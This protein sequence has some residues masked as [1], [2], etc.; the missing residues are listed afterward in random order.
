MKQ[1]LQY[2]R[3]KH[4]R[5]A[6]IPSP[7]LKGPG[8]VVGNRCSLISVG[9]E[10]QMI[11]VSQLSLLG[12]ARQ[13]PDIVKQVFSKLKTEG[14][15][16]TYNKVMGRLNSPVPL[17]YSSAGIVRQ[18]HA[19]IENWTVGERVACAGY[20]YA[21]HA[22]TVYVPV[23]L[24]VKIPDNVAN[25]EACFVTLG[26]I[27]MQ[28]IR[29][30]DVRLGERVAVIGLGLL[31]QI[32]CMLLAAAGCRVLGIDID[33]SKVEL[34]L[35]AGAEGVFTANGHEAEWALDA[36]SGRGVDATIITAASDT[37]TPLETAGRICREKGIVTVVGAVKLEVPR[38]TYYEKELDLRLSRSYGPG[39]YDYNYEEAG[40][41]YPYGYVR[42]TENRNMESFL[43][44]IS[45]GKINVK[46]LITHRFDLDQANRAYD[47][48]S[49]D[50]TEKY[51]GVILRY[52]ESAKSRFLTP[53]SRIEKPIRL[54]GNARIGVGFIGAGSF[55]SGVLL[56]SIR[57]IESFEPVAILSGSG[58]SAAAAADRFGFSK[59]ASSLSEILDDSSIKTVFIANRHDQHA[60]FVIESLARGKPTYVEKPLC[61]SRG[62][63]EQISRAY[64]S[65]SVPLMVGFNRRFSHLVE[66]IRE[67]IKEIRYPLSMHYRINAGYIP[68][69]NWIQDPGSG[70]G[71]IIG[72]ICH[73]V[74]LLSF[75][76]SSRPA[77]IS[78]EALSMPD[79]RYR[80]DDNLQIMIRFDSGSVGSINYMASGSKNMGKEYLEILGG[81]TAI[82]LDDFRVLT[83]ANEK[84]KAITR[85]R[86]QDK[87]HRKMLELWSY[88]LLAGL[89][90]PIP[91]EQ[92]V[93][94]TAAT[95]DIIDS[96]ME[97]QAKWLN[98]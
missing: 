96:L 98:V 58:I 74:D 83:I 11:E 42:W 76:S 90:S 26:A 7:Q 12:K 24:A 38:K 46:Q 8:L 15:T 16:S 52:V 34:A 51:L 82:T 50:S 14:I 5:V 84:G 67:S 64:D 9:T 36:T 79:D 28:G 95:F 78:A 18:V 44:L 53:K 37:A 66:K 63:L 75:L 43:Q 19:S 73:F 56:P 77:K 6:E 3:E 70:G 68:S 93:D 61:L 94:A 88:Y 92:I 80:S 47:L 91:F 32:T 49:G 20:G 54:Q 86:T 39:R 33:R 23:N 60:P 85:L 2:N 72:E 1:V 45:C 30:A 4:P 41:D 59:A 65:A 69:E 48:I 35:N 31:G 97:G 21:C 55:A 29:V 27:A 40:Q 10:R 17:G 81:G 13:R 25:E 57:S 62:E 22:E 89:G 87:G 71:R